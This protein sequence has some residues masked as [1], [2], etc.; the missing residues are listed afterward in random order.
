MLLAVPLVN[1][2]L[3]VLL[4]VIIVIGPVGFPV[5]LRSKQ[6]L[7]DIDCSQVI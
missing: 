5:Q 1:G 7:V 3:I 4:G 2:L 6:S